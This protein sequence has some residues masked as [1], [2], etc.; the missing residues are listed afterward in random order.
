MHN[1]HNF[2]QKRAKNEVIGHFIELGWFE[3]FQYWLLAILMS[4]AGLESKNFS[5]IYRE[6][7]VN[8]HCQLVTGSSQVRKSSCLFI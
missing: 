8:S 2:V 6:L 3:R 7:K 5:H 4:R 1:K